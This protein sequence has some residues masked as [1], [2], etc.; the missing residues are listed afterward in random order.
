MYRFW[1]IAVILI[2]LFAGP[3]FA[4]SI[5]DYFVFNRPGTGVILPAQITNELLE[6]IHFIDVRRPETFAN[7][8]IPGAVNL[9]W[10]ETIEARDNLPKDKKIILYCETGIQS[11]QVM[12]G[13]RLLGF[14][15]SV[16]QGGYAGWIKIK[17]EA[18][19]IKN[20]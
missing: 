7:G 8:N 5:E 14:D 10:E 13:L 17:N 12:L 4:E 11:A 16:L 9:P 20:H 18:Y 1:A 15:V 6:H 19:L 2:C 3:A